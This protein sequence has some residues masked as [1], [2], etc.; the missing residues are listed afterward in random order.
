MSSKRFSR[1][2]ESKLMSYYPLLLLAVFDLA[3]FWYLN[4][5]IE[6]MINSDD[7]SELMLGRLLA[8]ENKIVTSSWYYS[9]EVSVLNTNLI[10]SI[11]FR[12]MNNWHWIRMLSI[13]LLH[14][15]LFAGVWYLSR[16]AG[17]TKYF[18]FIAFPIMVPFSKAYCHMVIR[19]NFYVPYVVLTLLGAAFLFGYLREE[20]KRKLY[21]VLS[22]LLAFLSCTS[23]PRQVILLYLPMVICSVLFYVLLQFFPKDRDP[24]LMSRFIRLTVP[25]FLSSCAGIVFNILVVQP[26][27]YSFRWELKYISFSLG[28]LMEVI[29]G[30]LI[31]Y[32]Y[33]L[34]E[35]NMES[36]MMNG[37]SHFLFFLSIAAVAYALFNRKTVSKEYYLF[38]VLYLCQL[39]GFALLYCFT[40][41]VH[42]ARYSLPI[43]V[44]SFFVIALFFG[45]TKWGNAGKVPLHM[46][47][48]LSLLVQSVL[49]M[50]YEQR[51]IYKNWVFDER[52]DIVEM[53]ADRGYTKGYAAFWEGNILTELS[54]G[55]LEIWHWND[56]HTP[57]LSSMKD[58]HKWLQKSSHLETPP[59]GKVFLLLSDTL[60]EQ[61]PWK[62]N[63]TEDHLLHADEIYVYGYESFEEM[64]R[65]VERS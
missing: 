25:T 44:F 53:L 63:L 30:L 37:L 48:I 60:L 41:M 51:L 3:L 39:F 65:L 16:R 10:Y 32:G 52:M 54:N 19:S 21:L 17:V 47:Y 12:F 55:E 9:T 24:E 42:D 8:Q 27:V 29:N 40:S 14:L 31:D 49:S 34:E 38:T 50:V 64:V 26:Q 22:C 57:D 20:K 5:N 2:K 23:G 4:R 45:E 13:F 62:Q 7:A 33:R 35:V 61:F 36:T 11:M 28:N 56:P 43:I 59:E 1:F 46:L 15:I 18:P 6:R 58:L